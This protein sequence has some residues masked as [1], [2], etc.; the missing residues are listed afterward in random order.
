MKREMDQLTYRKPVNEKKSLQLGKGKEKVG[1][2]ESG[3]P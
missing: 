2:V 3:E 1:E